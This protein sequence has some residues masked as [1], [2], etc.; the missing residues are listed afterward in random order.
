MVRRC[1]TYIVAVAAV[2]L[3]LSLNNL[4][5]ASA[6]SGAP[7]NHY[8]FKI[9]SSR[10]HRLV[11]PRNTVCV[12]QPDTPQRIEGGDGDGYEVIGGIEF[13][14]SG[15]S[16]SGLRFFGC[17]QHSKDDYS[18]WANDQDSCAPLSGSLYANGGIVTHGDF[19][20][21]HTCIAPKNPW[22]Y[23]THYFITGYF[24]DTGAYFNSGYHVSPSLSTTC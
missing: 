5:P 22:F 8:V 20:F 7:S 11:A 4:Q 1:S 21:A 17:L 10:S 14:C 3:G 23:R 9:T 2:M 19:G 15:G 13:S 6:A 12:N 16:I 18:N 24:T